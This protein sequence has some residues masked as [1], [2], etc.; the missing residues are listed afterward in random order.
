MY[1]ITMLERM[2]K[3]ELGW[4]DTGCQRCVGYFLDKDEAYDAVINN[5]LDISD[6]IYNY[7]VIQRIE[8]GIY[9]NYGQDVQYF[10]LDASVPRG[11]KYF[12]IDEPECAKRCGGYSI[13]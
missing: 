7:A 13:G 12:Q 2:G 11:F 9:R 5:S 6:H 8:P 3:T 1:F 4:L 10:Q